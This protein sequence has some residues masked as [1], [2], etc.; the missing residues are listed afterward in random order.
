M[1]ALK[2]TIGHG[3]TRCRW[4]SG[5][6]LNIRRMCFGTIRPIWAR[7]LLNGRRFSRRLRMAGVCGARADG[8]RIVQSSMSRTTA[9]FFAPY[10]ISTTFVRFPVPHIAT[11][12]QSAGLSRGQTMERVP[13]SGQSIMTREASWLPTLKISISEIHGNGPN[14]SSAFPLSALASEST[15]SSM[16]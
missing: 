12:L 4:T 13:T 3:S 9:Q 16:P 11:W 1:M 15:T 5:E 6:L 14:I 7:G 8:F 2:S 10:S